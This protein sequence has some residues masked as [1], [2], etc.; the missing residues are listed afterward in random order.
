[1]NS[2]K[3]GVRAV[4]DRLGLQIKRQP[5]HPFPKLRGV[6]R[7]QEREVQLRGRP[8]R[9]S[10]VPSFLASYREIFQ[11]ELY[12]FDT[13]NVAPVIVDCGANYGVSV[14]CL[15][16]LYP[17]SQVTAV[18]A[19]PRI[20]AILQGNLRAADLSDLKL[21]NRAVSGSREPVTFH[22]EGAD[23]GRIHEHAGASLTTTV[24][25]VTL[26]ELIDGP[27]DFLKIDIEGAEVATLRRCT[28]LNDVAQ[29]FVEYHSFTSEPQELA[30]LLAI[31]A[32]SGFRYYIHT[33]YCSPRPLTLDRDYMG[34]D[35]QF[36]IFAKRPRDAMRAAA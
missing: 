23:A 34:M 19:D 8:F 7:Y 1:M 5:R 33:Q 29:M 35:M 13:S 20:F 28:K 12:R 32:D 6:P 25:S 10:D 17:N 21:L 31:F 3:A 11:E 18:E 9:V 26:D 4:A 36:N 14:R 2:V 27:V 16:Q 30:E 15:K 22:S 24:A